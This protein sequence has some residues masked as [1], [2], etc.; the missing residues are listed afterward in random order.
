MLVALEFLT[1]A[2]SILASINLQ[3]SKS[4]LFIMLLKLDSIAIES[5][6]PFRCSSTTI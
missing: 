2:F 6:F 5:R 3:L 1:S 4:A